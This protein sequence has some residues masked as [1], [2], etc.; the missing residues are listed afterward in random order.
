[1]TE[2]DKMFENA[3]F[4]KKQCKDYSCIV[5]EQNNNC[6]KYPPFTAEKQLELIKFLFN[7]NVYY[8]VDSKGNY[9]FHISDDC[10]T[11]YYNKFEVALANIINEMW[12]DLTDQEKE[13]IKELLDEN[14]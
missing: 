10:Y 7:H 3:G 9:W 5:C 12:Q 6:E 14:S 1:M 4:I 11:Y 2:I 8:D 13:E